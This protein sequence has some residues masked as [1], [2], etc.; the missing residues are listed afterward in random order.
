MYNLLKY[1]R[2][3]INSSIGKNI[4]SLY[5]LQLSSY[6]LPLITVPYLVRMLGPEKFGLVAF[7]Q[8]LTAFFVYLVNY[9]FDLTA[10]REISRKRKSNKD[11][12]NIACCVWSAKGILCLLG[13]SILLLLTL[14]VPKMGRNSILLLILFGI[15]VGNF[16]F[17]NWLFLGLERMKAISA[18]NVTMRAVT[19]AGVFILIR[20]PDDYLL[21]AGL[22]S[23]QWIFAGITGVVFAIGRLKIRMIVPGAGEILHVFSEGWKL[24]VSHMAQSI[25]L[26]GNSFILGMLTNY[27]AVGYYSAAEKII[28]S[29]LG[30]FRP[31][32]Q[33]VYPRFSQMAASSRNSVLL[34]GR[35]LI[36]VMGGLGLMASATMFFG[37]PLV[38]KIILGPGYEPSITVLQI[39]A[40]LPF[41]ASL[42]DV[43]SIQI[44]LPFSK[45]R[46]YAL[47]RLTTAVLHV[48]MAVLL[49][50][51]LHEVGMAVTLIIS[52]AFILISTFLCLSYWKLSPFHYKPDEEYG[53]AP[54]SG[55]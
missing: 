25:Y 48:S 14:F 47:I 29:L 53:T 20:N 11:V 38:A 36:F 44:M 10:T 6:I 8:S 2:F 51:K 37:A 1:I 32:A 7:G 18:I 17:P 39:L 28:F 35:R 4:I 43:L 54:Q 49:V 19:T 13:L 45:D 27:T 30:L 24:F 31:L 46:F 15:V 52:Q 34:W 55:A 9:G 50:P 41:L 42:S 26:I 22:L 16:L 5:V 23:F 21:Y 12:S 40:I 33:A 3:G